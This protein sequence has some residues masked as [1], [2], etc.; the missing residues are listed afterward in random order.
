MMIVV[1]IVEIS[2]MLI[3]VES[4]ENKNADET[5][6]KAFQGKTVIF[7]KSNLCNFTLDFL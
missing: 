6:F 3:I 5:A 2:L 1:N 4:E 7:S